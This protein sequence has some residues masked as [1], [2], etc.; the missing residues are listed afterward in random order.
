MNKITSAISS[1][2]ILVSD[3][4]WGTFLFMKGLKTGECPELWN[5]NHP[6]DV[7]DIAKSYVDAGSDI[8]ETNSFGGSIFKLQQFGLEDKVFELNKIA[9]QISRRAAGQDKIVMGSIGPTGKFLMMGDVTEENLYDSFKEQS[10]ALQSGGADAVC[11]ETFYALDEAEQAIKAV[12]DNTDLE[13]ITSFTFDKTADGTFKT[14]MGLSPQQVAESL[15]ILGADVIGANCGVGFESM[16]TI[17]KNIREVS[18]K[19]PIIVQSNA[20]LPIIEDG[21]LKYS[22]TPETIKEIIPRLIDAGANII[23]GCCGT[24]P[25]HIKVITEIVSDFNAEKNFND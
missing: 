2:K 18:E 25:E 5:F 10:L 21:N 24:T 19:I 15:V 22:E 16:I 3:G 14:L 9:A 7:F 11:I 8:I 17:I 4:A 1:G 13:I 12:R 6:E 23:G 20:G